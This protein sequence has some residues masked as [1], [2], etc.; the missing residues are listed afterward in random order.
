M[1]IVFN[2]AKE[3]KQSILE[4]RSLNCVYDEIVQVEV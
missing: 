2:T 3:K 1:E 4:R